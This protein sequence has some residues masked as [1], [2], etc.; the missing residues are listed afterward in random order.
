LFT[1]HIISFIILQNVFYVLW[2]DFNYSHYDGVFVHEP[3]CSV[4]INYVHI[5]FCVIPCVHLSAF[6][7][8]LDSAVLRQFIDPI[9]NAE[10]LDCKMLFLIA[11]EFPDFYSLTR[12]MALSFCGRD[13]FD[14]HLFYLKIIMEICISISLSYNHWPLSVE[15]SHFLL[16]NSYNDGD[17]NR[18]EFFYVHIV[19]LLLPG[20]I[21]S[22][23]VV[24]LTRIF[25]LL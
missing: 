18:Y 8:V 15:S 23:V 20:E 12:T 14:F 11:I 21:K 22:W 10:I 6:C 2:A 4:F 5:I 13:V 7:V 25:K 19:L 24:H 3:T 1:A 17:N 9:I 16:I